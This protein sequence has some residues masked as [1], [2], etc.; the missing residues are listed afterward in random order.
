ME[1]LDV[2]D[3]VSDYETEAKMNKLEAYRAISRSRLNCF[4]APGGLSCGF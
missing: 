1:L 2:L 4:G 3:R